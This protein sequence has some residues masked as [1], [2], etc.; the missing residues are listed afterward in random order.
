M[1]NKKLCIRKNSLKNTKLQKNKKVVD[2]SE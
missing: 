2:K 1:K